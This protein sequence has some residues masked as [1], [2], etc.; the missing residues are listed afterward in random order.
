MK[1]RNEDLIRLCDVP[2]L[3]TE[4][5][6]VTRTRATVYLWS[7]KGIPGYDGTKVR[8]KTTRR[9]RRLYTTKEWVENFLREL[10]R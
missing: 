7:S 4:L 2:K 1:P 8:L 6:G 9:L 5:A 10:N 3:L